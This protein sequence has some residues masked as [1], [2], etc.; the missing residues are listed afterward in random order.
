MGSAWFNDCI[1]KISLLGRYKLVDSL[2]FSDLSGS[3]NG[4]EMF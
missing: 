1:I 3:V 2:S 4:C